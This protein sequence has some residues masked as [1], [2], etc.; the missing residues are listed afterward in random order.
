MDAVRYP[1]DDFT[2]PIGS[3]LTPSDGGRLDPKRAAG[4]AERL[5]QLRNAR[6]HAERDL[7]LA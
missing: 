1:L 3:G 4:L 2:T 7:R 5:R 6:Q